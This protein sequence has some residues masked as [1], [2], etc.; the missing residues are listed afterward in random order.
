MPAA[1]SSVPDLAPLGP[2]FC[3]LVIGTW[4]VLRAFLIDTFRAAAYEFVQASL[5]RLLR[6]PGV[7][8]S[9]LCPLAR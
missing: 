6:V 7:L 1:A 5:R 2:S 9:L 4:R 8:P 3:L